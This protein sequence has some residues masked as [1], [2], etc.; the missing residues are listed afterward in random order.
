MPDDK[1]R[2]FVADIAKRFGITESDWRARVSRGHAP[3]GE[4]IVHG[5]KIRVVWSPATIDQYAERRAERLN[6]GGRS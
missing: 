6:R 2:L 3:G 1:G 4:L 5:G